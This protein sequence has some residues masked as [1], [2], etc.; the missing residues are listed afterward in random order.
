KVAFNSSA[1]MRTRRLDAF[2]VGTIA[3][4]GHLNSLLADNSRNGRTENAREFPAQSPRR[5][6]SVRGRILAVNRD[7]GNTENY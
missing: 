1:P 3:F 4:R 6:L 7:S 5:A 2:A